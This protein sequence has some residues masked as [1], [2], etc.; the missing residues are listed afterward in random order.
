MPQ[1]FRCEKR[2]FHGEIQVR[3][4]DF[5]SVFGSTENGAE[6]ALPF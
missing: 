3:R 1:R 6:N 4:D 5:A 2:K